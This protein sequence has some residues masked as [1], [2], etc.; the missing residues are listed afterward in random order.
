MREYIMTTRKNIAAISDQLEQIVDLAKQLEV[1]FADELARVHPDFHASARNLIAY[2]A[3]RHVDIR[4]DQEQLASLGLS[5]LGRAEKDVMASIRTVQKALSRI[6]TGKNY[7]VNEERLNFERSRHRL[8]THIDD[9]LGTRTDGRNVRIM[10]TLPTEAAEEYALVCNLISSGMDVARINCAHDDEASW[11]RMIE[12]INRAK[13]ETGQS[14]RIMMDLAGPKLRT[15]ELKPGPGVVRIRPKRD[16]LG[17]S[18]H[19]DGC[20]SYPKV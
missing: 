2:L 16:S 15:G 18:L 8:E 12:N 10:V 14:C 3:L 13:E 4:D 11:L 6:S 7:D 20:G 5:S 19:Q 17:R 1:R 9:V